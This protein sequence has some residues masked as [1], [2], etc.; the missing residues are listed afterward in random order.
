MAE[1]YV[2][3]GSSGHARVLADVI[4]ARAG[5][6]V[7]LFDNNTE[8]GSSLDGVPL[9]VGRDR[10][11]EWCVESRP[12][13]PLYGAIAIGGHRGEDRCLINALMES[14][15]IILPTLIHQSAVI[16]PSAILG[17][18]TQVLAGAIVAAGT[19]VDS[20]CIINN[21]ANIDHECTLA[22]GVH[23]APGAILCGCVTVGQFSMIGAGAVI[24]P[25]LKI[26]DNAIVG[27]GAVV[28]KNVPS[29]SVVFGNPAKR[30]KAR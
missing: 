13:G 11:V 9:Y 18:A 20:N 12:S 10:F 6:I 28:T 1:K 24:L 25:R 30:A 14:F 4:F 2:I 16:S 3:W 8:A 5:Q 26:G 19:K 15:G 7:A 22:Q 23:V 17:E 29:G 21:R 27:A